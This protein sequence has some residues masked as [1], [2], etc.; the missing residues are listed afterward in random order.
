MS[1]YN[2]F[3]KRL[4]VIFILLLVGIFSVNTIHA[5]NSDSISIIPEPVSMEVQEGSF[6]L[7][8]NTV[9][10][11]DLSQE[12]IKSIVKQLKKAIDSATG[13]DLPLV[14]LDADQYPENIISL[15]I[16]KES[17]DHKEGYQLSVTDGEISLKASTSTGLFY[18]I[19]SLLQ[20]LPAQIYQTD[21]TLVP[22]DTEWTIPAVE[23]EDYPRFAY[24]GLHL[25][26][27]R[28]LFPVDFIKRYIDL[29]AMH[30]MNRFHWHLTEDQ[31]WRIEIKQYPKLTE[32]GAWRDSTLVGHYGSDIYDG[33]RYGGYYTQDE[34][35]E[36]VAY[37]Q[38]KQVTVIPEIELP[39]HA[40]AALA[41]YPELGCLE[42]KN[43]KVQTT[44]GV[45]ED[46]YCPSEETFTFLENVLTEVMELFPSEY[47]HIGGD[48][49][50][51]T[52]WENSELA[53]QVIEREGLEDEH[54]LQSYFITRIEEFLNEHGRQIIGWDEILE[55]GLAPNATVMSWRGIQGG[56]EA[57]K[58]HHDVVMTP[59]THLYLDHYQATPDSEPLAI[60]GFTTLEKTYSYEPI[61]EELTEEESQYILGAQGNVWTEYMHSP[62]KVEY[63]AYPRAS[64][65]AEVNWSPKEKRNWEHFWQRLQTQFD[66]FEILGINAAEHFRGKQP[67]LENPEK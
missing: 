1:N 5:Q 20:L 9:I 42:N 57:A 50:P 33:E 16:D 55:G 39:G 3:I 60:G 56:I 26:V 38:K 48:E 15:S 19:Q 51:K 46:I 10:K 43:Y 37:A 63:M 4:Q 44:W 22:Q 53:Q 7:E 58:Q 28:H 47:I 25:D 23:I 31:G 27:G 41:A 40:S 61:P 36:I 12:E 62:E 34:V 49:A 21:Y 54:E 18:G 59:G 14:G 24:R 45:F 29:I 11:A 17:V 64:A 13:Y 52:Q 2:C 30:K 35:R 67:E 6:H 8:R 32:I 66:R 65:L